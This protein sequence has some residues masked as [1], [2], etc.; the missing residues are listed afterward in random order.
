[1]QKKEIIQITGM[2]CQGCENIVAEAIKKV[3]GVVSVEVSYIEGT[4]KVEYETD[5]TDILFIK[6]AVNNTHYK[7]QE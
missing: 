2:M 5:K 1:M 3:R 7:V 4:A 6:M